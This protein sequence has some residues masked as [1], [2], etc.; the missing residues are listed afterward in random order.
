[1]TFDLS[2]L[3]NFFK[4]ID[5]FTNLLSSFLLLS[6]TITYTDF[7]SPYITSFYLLF[8]YCYNFYFIIFILYISFYLFIL[9]YSYF[10]FFSFLY[11]CD[12]YI[13]LSRSSLI[14]IYNYSC[15]YFLRISNCFNSYALINC[16]CFCAFTAAFYFLRPILLCPHSTAYTI[17]YMTDA[18]SIT[19]GLYLIGYFR[20]CIFKK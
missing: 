8:L 2:L 3:F 18:I 9:Y 15:L 1:M 17:Y 7:L 11:F 10:N 20:I 13:F 4:D 16:F 19:N 6:S 5:F 14:Y 12:F